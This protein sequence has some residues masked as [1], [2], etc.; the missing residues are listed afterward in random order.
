MDE[1]GGAARTTGW[2]WLEMRRLA[3]TTKFVEFYF[4]L[5]EG[6]LRWYDDAGSHKSLGCIDVS[7][8][9]VSSCL[10]ARAGRPAF[11]LGKIGS[12][13]RFILAAETEQESLSWAE[14]M[15]AHGA[16]GLLRSLT[17]KPKASMSFKSFGRVKPPAESDGGIEEAAKRFGSMKAFSSMKSFG[18]AGLPKATV[19]SPPTAPSDDSAVPQQGDAAT[20]TRRRRA[21]QFE[22]ERPSKRISLEDR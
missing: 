8:T 9:E 19:A 13:D 21:V 3:R 6:T 16:M 17:A 20:T 15:I 4:V 14:S 7:S 18:R 22:E 2:L 11:R 5:D 12:N 10:F 1:A